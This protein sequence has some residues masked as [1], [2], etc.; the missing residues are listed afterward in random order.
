MNV[1]V[2]HLQHMDTLSFHLKCTA[3][4]LKLITVCILCFPRMRWYGGT[5]VTSKAWYVHI[6]APTVVSRMTS[7]GNPPPPWD[8]I[9]KRHLERLQIYYWSLCE[10]SGELSMVVGCDNFLNELLFGVKYQIHE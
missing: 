8:S 1:G 2:L 5:I 7:H 3:E 9:L 6:L 10:V 4:T